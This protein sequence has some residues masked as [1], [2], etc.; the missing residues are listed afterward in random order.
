MFFQ[1]KLPIHRQ[2]VTT[3]GAGFALL[4]PAIQDE[5][6]Q[7]IQN[8]QHTSGAFTNR[9]A[10]PDVY[11]SLF[12]L[13]LSMATQQNRQLAALKHYV[14]DT[15]HQPAGIIEELALMLI[16]T[17]LDASYNMP[18]V[19]TIFRKIVTRGRRIDGS[20]RFFL[21]ALVADA[22]KKGK[23]HLY[24][25]ARIWLICHKPKKNSLC[26][27]TAALLCAR[28]VVGLNTKKY[29]RALGHFLVEP[30]GFRAFQSVTAADSLSTAVALFALSQ[31]AYDL[32]LLSPGCLNFIRDNYHGGAFLSGD[33]DQTMDLE[34]TFYGLLALGSLVKGNEA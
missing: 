34:Y 5:I 20:Y 1:H 25:L 21:F 2:I 15:H 19:F 14:F 32:R 16:K 22:R 11:Y 18:S 10:Q 7:F 30:G 28:S 12:G 33:G 29:I 23:K 8:R 4:N 6:K 13:W 17:E 31:T 24:F 3:I 27:H 9:A 26:A